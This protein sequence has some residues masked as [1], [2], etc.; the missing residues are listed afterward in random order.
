MNDDNQPLILVS[1]QQESPSR[2]L[3]H[4]LVSKGIDVSYQF[5]KTDIGHAVVLNN[6]TQKDEAIELVKAFLSESDHR[7]FQQEAW[8]SG[9]SVRLRSDHQFDWLKVKGGLFSV[10]F[11]SL[12]LCVCI[13]V[14]L[15]SIMGWHWFIFSHLQMLPLSVLAESGQWWRLLGP[16]LFHFTA[17]HIIFNLLWWWTLGQQIER[18]LGTSSLLLIFCVTAIIPNILQSWVS[19]PNFGGLSGVVYGLFG[20]VWWLGWLKP[21]WGLGLP[22]SVIGF[23]LVWLVLG[24]ADVLWVTVANTAHTAGLVSGCLLA[25]LWSQLKPVNPT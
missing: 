1:F 3:I 16:A 12:I 24:Y 25:L 7:K 9:Q 13:V 6:A 4:F 14:Y 22:K 19:G 17:L 21:K 2:L 5:L 8:E 18:T 11:T 23:M 10:P 20:F 15:S